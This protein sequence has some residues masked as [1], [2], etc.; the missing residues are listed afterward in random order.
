[1]PQ[2]KLYH[3]KHGYV[4]EFTGDRYDCEVELKKWKYFYGK[5]FDECTVE[6]INYTKKRITKQIVYR[7]T[8]AIYRNATEAAKYTPHTFDTIK[9]HLKNNFDTPPPKGRLFHYLE[10]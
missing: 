2:I 10:E 8:G 1:M 5:K 4:K 7:P 3:P 6:R 9:K